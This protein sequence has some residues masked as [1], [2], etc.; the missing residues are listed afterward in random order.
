MKA[1]LSGL[2]FAFLVLLLI[3]AGFK[4]RTEIVKS[5]PTS[6]LKKYQKVVKIDPSDVESWFKSGKIYY[7]LGKYEKAK[8]SY[9]KALTWNRLYYPAWKELMWLS[10]NPALKNNEEEGLDYIKVVD[11]LNPTNAA[12]HWQ[13]LIR[14]LTIDEKWSKVVALREITLLFP[15]S[16]GREFRLFRIAGMLLGSTGKLA[17]FVPVEEGLYNNLLRFLLFSEHNSTAALELWERMK[18][19]GWTNDSNFKTMINGLFSCK[20]YGA[21]WSLWTKRYRRDYENNLIYNGSFEKRLQNYGFSWRYRKKGEGIKQVR[22]VHFY[23]ED[24]RKAFSIKFDGDRNPEVTNP[25][26]FVFLQPGTYKLTAYLSTKDLTS[27]SG[28][29]IEFSGPHFYVV[30]PQLKGD[31]DWEKFEVVFQLKH[32]GLYR[33]AL[34]RKATSKLNRFLG[35]EVFLDDVS[36]VRLNGQKG[37]KNS[38]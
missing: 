16:Q 23:R 18:T 8:R 24:G 13:I 14:M 34:R 38:S 35:G 37:P 1:F 36:L 20:D 3:L 2:I 15:L 5:W 25:Y 26:Q 10:L 21:A 9:I 27:A 31:T 17:S 7:A 32:S 22:C 12:G 30:S 33:V 29:F 4:L 28:F 19:K 11:L 6:P